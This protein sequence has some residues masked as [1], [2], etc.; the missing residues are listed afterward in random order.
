MK[1]PDQLA[2]DLRRLIKGKVLFDELSRTMY[3]TGACSYQ[4]M[5]LG[6]VA[7]R[8]TEDVIQLAK[9]CDANGIPLIGRG[10]AS[11]LCGQALGAGIIVDFTPFMNEVLEVNLQDSWVEV[12]P[13]VVQGV[14]NAQLLAASK[15]FPPDPSTSDYCTLGGMI[16]NNASGAHSVKYGSTIDYVQELTVILADGT[17]ARMRTWAPEAIG[18]QEW[19]SEPAAGT[20]EKVGRL[21][22]ENK[23]AI[24][25]KFAS[26]VDKNCC[27]Y[28]LDKVFQPDGLNFSKLFS[29]SEGTLGL[30]TSA[31]LSVLDKPKAD[32]L[33]LVNFDDLE[34]AGEAVAAILTLRPSSLEFMDKRCI[35]RTRQD[36]PDLAH[37]VPED[38]TAQLIVEF[39][40]NDL[41]A[42]KG[43]VELTEKL[44]CRDLK[45][46]PL[47]EKAYDAASKNTIRAVRKA[48]TPIMHKLPGPRRI[49]SFVED[50]A[51]EP[52]KLAQA[53]GQIQAI[54]GRHGVEAV[55]FGHA[56]Q[57]S[58]H[59]RP[60]LD[61]RNPTDVDIMGEVSEEVH[62]FVLGIGGTVSAEHGD[63][64]SRT[65]FVER[66]YGDTYPLFVEVK[67][68]FDPKNLMNPGKIINSDP[69]LA[70]RNLRYGKDYRTFPT[71]TVLH[72]SDRSFTEA[73]ELCHGCSQCRTILPTVACMCPIFKATRE[74]QASPRA[75]ANLLRAIISGRLEAATLY[76]REFKEIVDLCMTCRM[77][78][79]ECPSG[80]N[81]PKLV[82][83]A[84][85]K[86]VDRMG[87]SR[88]NKVLGASPDT[89]SRLASG[90][91]PLANWALRMGLAR[92]AMQT[93]TGL[94]RHRAYP[95]FSAERFS[96]WWQE[97]H[98]A[99]IAGAGGE[100]V[101]Y[102]TDSYAEFN[103]PAIARAVVSVLEKNGVAV[104][105]PAQR[106]S[107]MPLMTYGSF[108]EA[109]ETIK[110]NVRSLSQAVR[111]GDR[112][113]TAE[114]T[115]ALALREEYLAFY[116]RAETRLVA[117]H[118][119]ELFEYL[120]ELHR[121]G[122]LNT[123]FEEVPDTVGYHAPCHLRALKIGLPALEILQLIPAL[124]VVPIDEG[125]CG[126][127]GTYGFKK[128][129]Y[130]LSMK[131]GEKLFQALRRKEID[132]GV[133]ECSTCQLQMAQ[134]CGK[135]AVHP[136]LLLAR[137]YRLPV[138]WPPES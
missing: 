50:F 66:Q 55:V 77:C 73:V 58:V 5:P 75:K 38:M 71:E 109:L 115:A 67:R 97:H 129:N 56:G 15:F 130:D 94:H 112:I 13:G 106:S 100:R 3:S 33:A 18:G 80:V 30:I 23:E 59:V 127:A 53:I 17:E 46:A 79:T 110:H 2:K 20:L 45:L 51:V 122:K 81:V 93:A 86:F 68:L 120:L 9:Y 54:L 132:Y 1:S 88:T 27:G 119:S 74:E 117:E 95:A 84:R 118:T 39:D 126:I 123:D 36:R 128:K 135:P 91:A 87:Q 70:T 102:F 31:R 116:N 25:E 41:E 125:C 24:Q 101:A 28:R 7:P 72:F 6:A 57:G 8:D 52:T 69:E 4:I 40:G 103:N 11:G 29:A 76:S 47:L 89:L 111:E 96:K 19:A 99:A 82:L 43:K 105:V 48:L 134:G 64:L 108:P 83:E 121:A 113:L 131:V 104:S 138:E 124:T 63:G 114:P 34:K 12:Q 137:A 22:Q 21:L 98:R 35:D 14:L 133:S 136:V 42:L 85:A 26:F 16:A 65:Q 78:A 107:G 90:V 37:F 49:I 44:V 60:L 61:L 62:S 10:A 32:V 92:S